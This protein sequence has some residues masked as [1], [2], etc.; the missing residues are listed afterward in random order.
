MWRNANFSGTISAGTIDGLNV[1]VNGN[2][3]QAEGSAFKISNFTSSYDARSERFS[4]Q[5][6]TRIGSIDINSS[7]SLNISAQV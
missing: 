2:S 1:R 7:G 3:V 6:L 4:H 5:N